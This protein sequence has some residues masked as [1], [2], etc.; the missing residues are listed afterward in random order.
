MQVRVTDVY[1]PAAR[2]KHYC[3]P[4]EAGTSVGMTFRIG[5]SVRNAIM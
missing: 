4:F 3:C 2:H 1:R 5:E